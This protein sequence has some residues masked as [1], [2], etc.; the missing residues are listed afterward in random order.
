MSIRN[1]PWEPTWFVHPGETLREL[2]TERGLTQAQA[3]GTLGVAPSY[4]SDVVRGRR[5]ISA[6]LAVRI[7]TTLGAGT[8]RFWAHLQA[9]YDVAAERHRRG[10][11]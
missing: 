10:V 2:L 11:R 1:R 3:A 7:E 4:L 5:A 6:A 8:A 9:D